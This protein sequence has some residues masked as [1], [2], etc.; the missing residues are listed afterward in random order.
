MSSSDPAHFPE[1]ASGSPRA[2]AVPRSSLPNAPTS[3]VDPRGEP[4]L[5]AFAGHLPSVIWDGLRGANDR[6][7]LWRLLHEKKWHY[8]SVAGPRAVVAAVVVDLGW[9]ATAWAYVFDR[10]TRTLLFDKSFLGV[11]KLTHRVADR[12]G[13]G[14]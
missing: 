4:N 3:A 7:R 9:T 2:P 8:A 12:A 14:A 1:A 5:G 6:G 11:P 13:E 10:Q